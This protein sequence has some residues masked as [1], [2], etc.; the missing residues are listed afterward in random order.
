MQD[1]SKA[2]AG[3]VQLDDKVEL[4]EADVTQSAE[5][6]GPPFAPLTCCCLVW[7]GAPCRKGLM[8]PCAACALLAAA[9]IRRLS[10]E[11]LMRAVPAT[12]S[13]VIFCSLHVFCKRLPIKVLSSAC[14][15]LA[16]AMGNA[17]AVISAIGYGGGG[18][19]SGYK[20]VDNEVRVLSTVPS[21]V[22]SSMHL[23]PC[24]SPL[25]VS[26]GLPCSMMISSSVQ[27][28]G[29]CASAGMHPER[30]WRCRGTRSLWM[31]P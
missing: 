29:R 5:Y 9:W 28:A 22:P 31:R 24:A 19:A 12:G 26:P 17:D 6:V 7:G 1:V 3:G 23:S 13:L 10:L 15:S 4:V 11:C 16:A 14:S 18:D 30:S 27:V 20:A 8:A 2:K 25:A 21:E